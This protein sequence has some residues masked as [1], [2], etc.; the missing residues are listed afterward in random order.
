MEF[1]ID[2]E[3]TDGPRK[4][5]CNGKE[6]GEI[7]PEEGRFEWYGKGT[8][9]IEGLLR[10]RCRD[11]R[12]GK[13]VGTCR[14][15][16]MNRFWDAGMPDTFRVAGRKY[17]THRDEDHVHV[18]DREGKQ[19]LTYELDDDDRFAIWC[20]DESTSPYVLISLAYFSY[21]TDKT[22]SD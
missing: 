18:L 19:V 10:F 1:R 2:D 17:K 6:V 21:Y 9:V 20:T 12:T 15:S 16:L 11:A 13:V 7:L 3:E 4:I 14:P 8:Y 5:R 22:M